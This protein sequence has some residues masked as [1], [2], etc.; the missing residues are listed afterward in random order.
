MNFR[1]PLYQKIHSYIFGKISAFS[2]NLLCNQC[3]TDDIA[4]LFLFTKIDACIVESKFYW[5]IFNFSPSTNTFQRHFVSSISLES[6]S[7]FSLLIQHFL[8]IN[9]VGAFWNWIILKWNCFSKGVDRSY[10]FW[11][12]GIATTYT[13]YDVEFFNDY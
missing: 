7:K 11:E 4:I 6:I 12:F 2:T 13:V 1:K 9:L 10:L 8:F 5:Y 3:M